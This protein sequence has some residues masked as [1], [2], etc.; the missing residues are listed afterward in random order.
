MS[1]Y[2][3]FGDCDCQETDEQKRQREERQL[4]KQKTENRDQVE[5]MRKLAEDREAS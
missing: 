3:L 1:H 4:A 2:D 5:S